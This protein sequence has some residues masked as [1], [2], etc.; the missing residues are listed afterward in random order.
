MSRDQRSMEGKFRVGRVSEWVEI[1]P[2]QII[3][4]P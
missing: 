2:R 4:V 3:M 1:S